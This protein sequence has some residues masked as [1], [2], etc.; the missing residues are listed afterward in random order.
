[1]CCSSSTAVPLLCHL[2]LVLLHTSQA[3]TAPPP[4]VWEPGAL[5]Y[6]VP[7]YNCTPDTIRTKATTFLNVE[8]HVS[9]VIPMGKPQKL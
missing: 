8:L 7:T 6:F 2:L 5:H 9:V 3:I 1:M 4:T